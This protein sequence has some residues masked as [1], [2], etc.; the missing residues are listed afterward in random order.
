MNAGPSLPDPRA[1]RAWKA[2]FAEVARHL[3]TLPRETR[4]DL[5]REIESHALDLLTPA[6]ASTPVDEEARVV[7]ALRRLGPPHD[8]VP[9]L[10]SERML[11]EAS[12]TFRPRA[13]V[14]AL[15]STALRGAAW[16]AIVAVIVVG[17]LTVLLFAAGGVWRLFA[18]QSVGFFR[19][20]GGGV[21]LAILFNESTTGQDLLGAWTSPILL[22]LAGAGYAILTGSLRLLRRRR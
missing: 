17:Y 8:Y 20:P 19:S 15:A 9:A 5:Q 3:V 1:T 18:P 21:R 4:A 16:V 7:A 14:S 10:V 22:V 11:A 2:Y 12:A 13:V 6:D